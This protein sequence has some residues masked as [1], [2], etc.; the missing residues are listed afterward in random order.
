[1]DHANSTT[2]LFDPF[3]VPPGFSIFPNNTGKKNPRMTITIVAM[4]SVERPAIAPLQAA[5]LAN[6]PPPP[7]PPNAPPQPPAA[8][9]F[10]P[11][12]QDGQEGL[13]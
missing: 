4:G 2:L 9:P 7:N 1:M 11:G 12:G 8:D 10:K 13:G 6:P 5:P 3:P